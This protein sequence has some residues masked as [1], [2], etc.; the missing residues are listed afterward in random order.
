MYRVH[1][2]AGPGPDR[3]LVQS[4]SRR[5]GVQLDRL[6]VPLNALLLHE[7]V[8]P[9]T[10]QNVQT[11]TDVTH[12]CAET[13]GGGVNDEALGGQLDPGTCKADCSITPP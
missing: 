12:P 6:D 3:G 4:S 1:V 11:M 13:P 9:Q 5:L 7:R 10:M 2:N 8:L